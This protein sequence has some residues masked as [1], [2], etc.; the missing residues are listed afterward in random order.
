MALLSALAILMAWLAA[1]ACRFNQRSRKRGGAGRGN[2]SEAGACGHT[3]HAQC[4][5]AGSPS[6]SFR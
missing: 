5:P 3:F 4:R 2:S 1:R 6:R